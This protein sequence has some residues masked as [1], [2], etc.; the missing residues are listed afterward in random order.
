M[1]A[2]MS[3]LLLDDG[4]ACLAGKETFRNF[5]SVLMERYGL[6]RTISVNL[7]ASYA[8]ILPEYGVSVE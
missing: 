1:N 3:F 8:A 4:F 6:I 2:H 7:Q 5:S